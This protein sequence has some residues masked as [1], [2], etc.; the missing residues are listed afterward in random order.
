MSEHER[1]FTHG[2]QECTTTRLTSE[3]FEIKI[4]AISICSSVSLFHR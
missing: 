4:R 2:A 3:Y 1:E